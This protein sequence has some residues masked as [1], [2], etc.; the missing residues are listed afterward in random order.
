MSSVTDLDMSG[1][2]NC[3]EDIVLDAG[4]GTRTIERSAGNLQITAT[5][6]TVTVES[7]VFTGA[8]VSD[9]STL[10]MSSNLAIGGNID[11]ASGNL[12]ITA[13]GTTTVESVVFSGGAMSSVTDLDMSGDL[14]CAEDIV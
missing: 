8:A 3:G 4:S 14:N 10:T 1:D 12:V 13:G 11:R 5:S 6:G 7:V 9:V 2:L